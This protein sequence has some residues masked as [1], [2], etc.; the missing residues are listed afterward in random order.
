MRACACIRSRLGGARTA[1]SRGTRCPLGRAAR[2][3]KVRAFM[4]HALCAMRYAHAQLA[5]QRTLR[6]ASVADL[7]VVEL[8]LL[9]RSRSRVGERVLDIGC[10]SHAARAIAAVH[11]IRMKI[12]I[13]AASRSRGRWKRARR[14]RSDRLRCRGER[15]PR[16]RSRAE[17]LCTFHVPGGGRTN[18]GWTRT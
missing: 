2:A 5:Q 18:Q 15:R 11:A 14:L 9:D 4:R 12:R 7:G 1:T 16:R 13:S 6:S 17:A 8:R 3:S 10:G